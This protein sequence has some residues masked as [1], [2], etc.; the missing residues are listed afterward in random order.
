MRR[1]IEFESR[2]QALIFTNCTRRVTPK[3][4]ITVRETSLVRLIVVL[5]ASSDIEALVT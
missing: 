4:R 3:R 5:R 2:G 1:V